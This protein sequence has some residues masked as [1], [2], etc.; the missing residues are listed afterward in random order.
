LFVFDLNFFIISVFEKALKG[1][2]SSA[3]SLSKCNLLSHTINHE[4]KAVVSSRTAVNTTLQNGR[5]SFLTGKAITTLA[6]KP[7]IA[8]NYRHPAGPTLQP[9]H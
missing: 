3:F 1:G 5:S 7:S 9:L 4:I 8:I 2:L 6:H